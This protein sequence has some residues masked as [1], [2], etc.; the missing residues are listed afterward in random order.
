MATTA[1]N[2]GS[3]SNLNNNFE[4]DKKKAAA[5]QGA[6]E[7]KRASL[8]IRH[9]YVID[10]FAAYVDEKP[11]NIENSLLLGNKLELINDF[12]A[13]GGSKK[14]ILFWQK[15]FLFILSKINFIRKKQ[16]QQREM[17]FLQNLIH[18]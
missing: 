3:L 13:D 14:V 2:I 18:L 11:A 10:K 16:L 8:D 7:K 9:R 4:N 15:V 6:I 5:T 12:F 1:G 17:Q